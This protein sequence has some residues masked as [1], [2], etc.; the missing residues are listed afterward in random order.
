[1]L[2][3][4]YQSS[5]L[6]WERHQPT[7]GATAPGLQLQAVQAPGP[8]E[9]SGEEEERQI[10]AEEAMSRFARNPTTPTT[11]QHQFTELTAQQRCS[12]H[13]LPAQ[14]HRR[15]FEM[16]GLR[17]PP[18]ESDTPVARDMRAEILGKA[19]ALRDLVSRVRDTCEAERQRHLGNGA[20]LLVEIRAFDF[21][22]P[23]GRRGARAGR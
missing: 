12:G 20:M 19:Q 10:A 3:W 2:R 4:Q 23:G 14:A 13:C 8:R 22:R 16:E 7:S 11:H 18:R 15:V 17:V 21:I 6:S 1:V 9:R 5:L